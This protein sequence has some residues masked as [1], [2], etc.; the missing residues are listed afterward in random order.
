MEVLFASNSVADWG[1]NPATSSDV[2]KFDNT[3]VPYAILTTDN[4]TTSM[5]D[6]H[7]VPSGDTVWYHYRYK[8]GSNLGNSEDGW[9]ANILDG[10]G[11]LLARLDLL[12]GTVAAVAYGDSTVTGTFASG[13]SSATILEIDVSV[14]VNGSTVEVKLYMGQA[15]VSTATAAN[16]GGRTVA[17]R[18]DFSLWDA[19]SSDHAFSEF[20][21]AADDTRNARMTRLD[22]ATAGNYSVWSGALA[23]LSDDDDATSMSSGTAAERNSANMDAYSGGDTIAAVV[24]VSRAA[25]G[26]G[27]PS[28]LKQFLRIGGVD[29]DGSNAPLSASLATVVE[30]WELDP[31]D[32]LA[33]DGAGVNAAE[34][35]LLSVT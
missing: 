22:P 33:W 10:A 6:F 21:V 8:L 25:S 24:A 17:R 30:C 11:A 23:S 20:L 1:N 28:N 18:F 12:D 2:S 31:S 16:T 7:A 4:V 26:A 13:W 15:L 9:I 29:Y 35:G 3:R 32:T 14:Q 34:L 19:A 27:A 5:K